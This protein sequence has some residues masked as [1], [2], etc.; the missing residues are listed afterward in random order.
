MS[1]QLILEQELT[2]SQILRVYGK[3]FRQITERYSDAQNGRCAMGVIVS[4][5]GR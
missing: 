2:V 3:Q 5:Y 4:Y 1:Q